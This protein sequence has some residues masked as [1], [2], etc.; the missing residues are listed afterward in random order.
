MDLTHFGLRQR[1]FRATPD[2]ELYYPATGHEVALAELRRALDE[3]E[4]L[5][6]LTGAPGTGK[7]LLAYRLIE[8]LAESTRAVFVTNTHYQLR[9]DLLQAILFDLSLPYAGRSEQ[10]LR[11]ALTESCLEQFQAGGKTILIVD[12]AHHL[13]ADHLEEL[14]LLS[15]LEGRHGKAVQVIL[16][17]LRHLRQKLDEP[18]Y[19]AVRQRIAVR[20]TLEPL[21]LEESADYLMHHIRIA[22]ARPERIFGDEALELLARAGRGVPRLL[23]QAG[24]AALTLA[25]S[26]GSRQVDVEAALEAIA[27]LG[28]SLDEESAATEPEE[29]EG[30]MSIGAERNVAE[31]FPI[32]S[33]AVPTLPFGAGSADEPRVAAF[34]GLAREPLGIVEI[35]HPDGTREVNGVPNRAG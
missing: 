15:N 11:L 34:G 9:S 16:V 23:N 1:P 12:E 17:G 27:G 10:E 35:I 29:H 22:G 2:T 13:A 26:V 21:T 30:R 19:A 7:T 18:V 25:E 3:E 8:G 5:A 32:Q 33:P 24:H 31:L 6:L 20:A 28:L 14:R 4:G